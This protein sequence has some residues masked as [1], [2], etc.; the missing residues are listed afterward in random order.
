MS[1]EIRRI[2]R[3]ASGIPVIDFSSANKSQSNDDYPLYHTLYETPF[4]NEHLLDV[5]NFA[6]SHNDTF[7]IA[8]II[9][10]YNK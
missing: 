3:F 7:R 4:T 1:Q 2:D 10:K 5:D 8:I 6:V 9:T